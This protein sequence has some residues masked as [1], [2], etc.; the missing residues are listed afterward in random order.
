MNLPRHSS[1]IGAGLLGLAIGWL[2]PPAP[3]SRLVSTG[4]P[5]TEARVEPYLSSAGAR[6]TGTT[7]MPAGKAPAAAYAKAWEALKRRHLP[8]AAREVIQSKL[9][10]EWS[11]ADLE[12]ALHAALGETPGDVI[13]PEDPF[14]EEP[15]SA[16]SFCRPGIEARPDLALEWIHRRAFGIE[17]TRLGREWIEVVGKHDP[18]RLIANLDKLPPH[19]Q[20]AAG[21]RAVIHEADGGRKVIRREALEALLAG[22][23]STHGQRG[24]QY[25]P[26]E[27]AFHFKLVELPAEWNAREDSVGR[28]FFARTAACRLR[29]SGSPPPDSI[30]MEDLPPDFRAAVEREQEKLKAR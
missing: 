21:L 11:L 19:L 17:T 22:G 6:G 3:V 20:P 5:G 18:F 4:P 10:G 16:L 13:K 23:D 1:F 9:F 2:A 7:S 28:E 12:S 25:L 27:L 15:P 29:V 14:F 8:R 24:L 26:G 30:G